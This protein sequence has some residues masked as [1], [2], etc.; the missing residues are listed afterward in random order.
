[1]KRKEQ[2][3]K[4]ILLAR[5]FNNCTIIKSGNF[6]NS[7]AY[8]LKGKLCIAKFKNAKR[9]IPSSRLLHSYVRSISI[10]QDDQ[11]LITLFQE[12][13]KKKK[14]KGEKKK[15]FFNCSTKQLKKLSSVIYPR[16]QGRR[17]LGNFI[18]TLIPFHRCSS[19]SSAR[20][21]NRFVAAGDPVRGWT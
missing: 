10:F 20:S 17:K 8:P 1:M 6:Q 4:I 3:D 18:N 2:F 5:T 12:K 21:S 7:A 16:L 11:Y 9:L 15:K 13:K 14:R 19:S